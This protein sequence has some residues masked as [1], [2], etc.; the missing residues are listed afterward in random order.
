MPHPTPPVKEMLDAIRSLIARDELNDVLQQL[1][2]LLGDHPHLDEAIHQTGRFHNIR[3]QIRLGLVSHAEATLTQNQIRFG[4]LEL[5]REIEQGG[6]VSLPR[7]LADNLITDR[8]RWV[9]S[10]KQEFLRRGIAVNNRPD[11][12]IQYFGWLIEEYLRKMQTSEGQQHTLRAFSYMTEAWQSSLR[13]LCYIQLAQLLKSGEKPQNA[14]LSGFIAMQDAYSSADS[15]TVIEAEAQFDYLSL[16]LVG[17]DLLLS[18]ERF[19][20][21]IAAFVQELTNAKSELFDTTRFLL[22]HRRRLLTNEIKEDELLPNLIDEYRTALVYWLR[23]TAFLSKYRMVSIKE[24]SLNYRL[25]TTQRFVHL[26]GELHGVYDQAFSDGEDY[27]FMSIEGVFTYSHSVLL[28]K[29]NEIQTCLQNI[30]DP[31]TYLSLSPLVIDQSV[32]SA[33]NTDTPEIYYYAGSTPGGR[34]YKYAQ[35]N[36]ELPLSGPPLPSNKVLRVRA[37]NT[38]QPKLNELYEQLETVFGPFKAPAQ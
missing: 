32:F 28:F 3:K 18:T 31:G 13:Y 33:K 17:A 23:K 25:G 26:Y 29:G 20:P 7:E 16:L 24:I 38:Q 36:N 30:G 11:Q 15:V 9:E 27:N 21:E 6:V 14:I 4:L 19:V 22:N 5:L 12:I 34:Q 35:Y 37:E 2:Q 1:R 8:N 10:L